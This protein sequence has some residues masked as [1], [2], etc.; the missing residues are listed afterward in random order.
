MSHESIAQEIADAFAEVGAELGEGPVTGFLLRAGA[1]DDTTMPPTRG[2]DQRLQVGLM[3]DEIGVA[4]RRRE[5]IPQTDMVVL[6]D[7][8]G[9]E[10]L[11]TD[12]LELDGVEHEIINV[13]PLRPGGA[14]LLYSVQVRK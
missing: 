14:A 7:A 2:P 9:P 8:I 6:I 4:D 13:E 5:I 11:S 10:P 12:R 3:Y 1:R